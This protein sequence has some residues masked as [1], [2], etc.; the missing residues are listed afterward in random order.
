MNDFYRVLKKMK[1]KGNSGFAMATIINV[2]GSAYRHP[3]AKM[4]FSED[5]SGYGTISAGCLEDD[6]SYHAQEVMTI[7]EPNT[8]V[9]DLRSEDDL[10]WGQGAGCNGSVKVYVE[11]YEWGYQPDKHDEPVWPRVEAEL[12]SGN[13]VASARSVSDNNKNRVHLLYTE[14]GTVLGD[15]DKDIKEKLL[16]ELQRF[17]NGEKKIEV[18][19]VQDYADDFLFEL[20]EPREQLYIFGAGP[21]VEP[22]ARLASDLDFFVTIIDPRSSH[23]NERLFPTA[24]QLIVE[25][26]DSY[27]TKKK[28]S[29]KSYVL[30]MTHSFQRDQHI[31]RTLAQTPLRYLGVLGPRRRTERLMAPEPLSDHIHSPL[32]LQIGAEGPEEISISIVAEL[33][34]VRNKK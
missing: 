29:D 26:P 27:L 19:E 22:L 4:L 11:P 21:D 31:L 10:T 2:D 18:V 6:L 16:P 25:H 34:K 33:L 13:K 12:E 30:I 20:Y 24:D 7:K 3:G 28:F 8:F 15:A 1:E 23:C 9:Y 14:K 17:I 32:G 5:G